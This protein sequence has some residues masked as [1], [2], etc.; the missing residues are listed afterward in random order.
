MHFQALPDDFLP[1]LGLDFLESVYY[2][3]AFSSPFGVNLVAIDASRPVGFV[4][5][6]HDTRGFSR[7]VLRRKLFAIVRYALMAAWRDPRHLAASF[8][9]LW[10]VL[11]SGPDPV[12]G[13]IVLIAVDRAARGAGVG[14]ALVRASLTY[15]AEHHVS[16]CRTKTLAGNTG[17]ISMYEGLGWHV[18]DRFSLIGRDYV[19]I[20]S[21]PITDRKGT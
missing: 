14:R 4:T 6:A 15:L 8:E 9:V 12:N 3:A 10:S 7:D 17:V 5:V 11:R 13:E 19:T 16:Q 21:P 1:S 20:V 2:P 18:R